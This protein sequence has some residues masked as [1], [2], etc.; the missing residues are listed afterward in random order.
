MHAHHLLC[1]CFRHTQLRIAVQPQQA[2]HDNHTH[3]THEHPR[4]R[5]ASQPDSHHTRT[6]TK[7]TL[8]TQPHS[9]HSHA[10]TSQLHSQPQVGHSVIRPRAHQHI[11]CIVLIVSC[12]LFF[13]LLVAAPLSVSFPR[14]IREV[15]ALPVAAAT[16]LWRLYAIMCSYTAGHG[17]LGCVVRME[18]AG[19]WLDTA[20]G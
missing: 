12:R 9:H 16:V 17:V 8:T 20:A 2:Q 19:V 5:L 7:A 15:C 13:T 4:I 3:S 14:P 11:V 6:R 10:L 18:D 1:P